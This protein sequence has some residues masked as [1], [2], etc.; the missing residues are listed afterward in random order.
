M[1]RSAALTLAAAM[2]LAGRAYADDLGASVA[3][4][5]VGWPQPLY[6]LFSRVP[7]NWSDLPVQ[8]KLQESVGYNSNILSIP[9]NAGF[10][11]PVGSLQSISNFEVATKGYWE[12]QQLFA[13]ASIG[14]YRYFADT[15]LNSV[16]NS[17]EIGDN[18]TYGSKCS[19][20]LSFSEQTSPSQPGFQVGN[21]VR[22]VVTN[23]GANETG[24]CV[25]SGDYAFLLNA[26][27]TSASNSADID[28]INDYQSVFVAAGISY[29]VSQTNSL[30][31]LVTITGT[32]YSD[33]Q[34]LSTATLANSSGLSN[35]ITQ[36]QVNLTYTKNFSP[37]VALTASVGV[38]GIR[39]KAFTLEPAES[40]EPVFSLSANWNVTPKL[41]LLGSISRSVSPP[42]SIIANAQTSESANIGLSYVLT[43][44]MLFAGGFQV[45]R[46]TAFGGQQNDIVLNPTFA[47]F[48]QN[49]NYYSA[50]ASINYTITPFVTANLSYTHS[51]TVQANLTT[52]TDMVLLALTFSP[53]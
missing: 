51:K 11:R 53:Y 38:V 28:K 25:I 48:T 30:Q 32:S 19:G 31:L 2:V 7:E 15:T 10:G 3:P 33:R 14:L 23:L 47:P 6:G 35:D 26:G 49:S 17:F 12:G 21:N 34:G 20:K 22:N 1:I 24:Q 5:G 8:L 29:T 52:P 43:P 13:D 42:T 41:G 50:N 4:S 40:F 16:T 18:W 44:K 37:S 45:S 39:N 27:T 46:S 36:D 9:V